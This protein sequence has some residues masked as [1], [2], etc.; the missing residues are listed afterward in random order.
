LWPKKNARAGA[1]VT[2]HDHIELM[3]WW[4][5]NDF[6]NECVMVNDLAFFGRDGDWRRLVGFREMD[7]FGKIEQ[8][9]RFCVSSM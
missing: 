2:C 3:Q 6:N 1:P 7:G 8:C 9:L 5:L 4:H